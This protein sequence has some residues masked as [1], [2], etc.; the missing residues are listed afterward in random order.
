MILIKPFKK[1]TTLYLSYMVCTLM[2]TQ[3]QFPILLWCHGGKDNN[4]HLITGERHYTSLF[5]R[6]QCNQKKVF[7]LYNYNKITEEK[8]VS[9]E[10]WFRDKDIMQGSTEYF[11]M[12]TN[13]DFFPT[14]W[15]RLD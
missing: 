11:Y 13:I 14:N 9:T 7:T 1:E 12:A 3:V 10:V 2:V 5:T 15:A 8:A 4:F 6:L